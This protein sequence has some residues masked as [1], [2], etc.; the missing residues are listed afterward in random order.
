MTNFFKTCYRYFRLSDFLVV[1]DQSKQDALDMNVVSVTTREADSYLDDDLMTVELTGETAKAVRQAFG[2][3]DENQKV[4]MDEETSHIGYSE[5]TDEL[6]S[7]FVVRC[8]D[9][10]K[11]FE[12]YDGNTAPLVRFVE[13]CESAKITS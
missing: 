11:E 5:W 1:Y 13:W 7:T 2:I 4:F 9:Q 8:G 10:K 12:Q 3:K 6:D